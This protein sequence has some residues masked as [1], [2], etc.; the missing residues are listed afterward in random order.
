MWFLIRYILF[1]ITS[2]GYD[3]TLGTIKTY[4]EMPETVF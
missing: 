2:L 3:I 1:V 4:S